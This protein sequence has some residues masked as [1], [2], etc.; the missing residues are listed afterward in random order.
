MAAAT[1]ISLRMR[2][3]GR[4]LGHF[5]SNHFAIYPKDRFLQFG[6]FV[7]FFFGERPVVL[8]MSSSSILISHP[9]VSHP[10]VSTREGAAAAA[11]MLN[12]NGSESRHSSST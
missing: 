3:E 7:G 1:Q 10:Q 2:R 8:S 12:P 4:T 5:Y 11:P 9:C 6:F